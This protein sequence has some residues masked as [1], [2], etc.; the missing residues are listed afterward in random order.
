MPILRVMLTVAGEVAR[1]TWGQRD[2]QE[3][4]GAPM[5]AHEAEVGVQ[6]GRAVTGRDY[7]VADLDA[8]H[9]AIANSASVTLPGEAA[10][11][12]VVSRPL[13]LAEK[14]QRAETWKRSAV[15][16]TWV[17]D[18]VTPPTVVGRKL[19]SQVPLTAVEQDALVTEW[20][21]AGSP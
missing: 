21:L 10:A 8:W 3:P 18:G 15:V 12:V 17:G 7:V 2:E 1:W 5:A 11:R 20:E 4:L 16:A 19:L 9:A 13:S 14:R 6:M